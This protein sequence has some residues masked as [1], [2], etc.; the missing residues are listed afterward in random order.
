MRKP[1]REAPELNLD[2]RSTCLAPR[3]FRDA[4]AGHHEIDPAPGRRYC[5][6]HRWRSWAWRVPLEPWRALIEAETGPLISATKAEDMPLHD[7]PGSS[8]ATG[9]KPANTW[10][11]GV[12]GEWAA[13]LFFSARSRKGKGRGWDL[14]LFDK[15][16]FEV[17]TCMLGKPWISC[18]ANKS[19]LPIREDIIFCISNPSDAI[20]ETYVCGWTK[21]RDFMTLSRDH[22]WGRTLDFKAEEPWERAE[23]LLQEMLPNPLDV[24]PGRM[25]KLAAGDVNPRV[26]EALSRPINRGSSR[27]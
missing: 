21:A 8:D 14:E 9:A 16:K 27:R 23:V 10:T 2:L 22:G 25:E 15:S 12:C 20:N 5:F 11:V 24:L 1:P 7:D 13:G 26:V 3:C 4:F 17:K 6:E 18:S 19:L